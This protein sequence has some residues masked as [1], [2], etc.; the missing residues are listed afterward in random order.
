MRITDA[1]CCIPAMPVPRASP[2]IVRARISKQSGC[3]EGHPYAFD[4][5]A[6]LSILGAGRHSWIVCWPL[7][8]KPGLRRG[9][10]LDC[11]DAGRLFIKR[12]GVTPPA[13]GDQSACPISQA[14]HAPILFGGKD[15][16][17]IVAK[18]HRPPALQANL[19]GQSGRLG[20]LP[21]I[22]RDTPRDDSASAIPI[23]PAK[24]KL[25]AHSKLMVPPIQ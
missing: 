20:G 19:D 9:C 6:P 8:R 21:G 18:H 24:T 23:D 2:Q 10:R 11:P 25:I 4:C 5:P 22:M 3:K 13:Q 16:Y 12:A 14:G 7:R 17:P 1:T 15:R